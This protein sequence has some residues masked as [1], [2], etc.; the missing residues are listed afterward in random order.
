MYVFGQIQMSRT[1][2]ECV[3]QNKIPLSHIH[4][5][6]DNRV[7]VPLWE[8]SW[9]DPE[10]SY[11]RQYGAVRPWVGGC[12]RQVCWQQQENCLYCR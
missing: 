7:W 2:D 11:P 3:E 4:V 1:N 5:S 8:P 10:T 9:L 12:G 6:V